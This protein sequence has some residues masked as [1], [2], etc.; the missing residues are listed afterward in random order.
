MKPYPAC[1][2]CGAPAFG[3]RPERGY[4]C[5]A[6]NERNE[7]KQLAEIATWNSSR[8]FRPHEAIDIAPDDEAADNQ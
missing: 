1:K 3:D 7:R 4:V 2:C 6:C 8:G 5:A